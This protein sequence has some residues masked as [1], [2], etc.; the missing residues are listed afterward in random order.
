MI[1]GGLAI[2]SRKV[3]VSNRAVAK[4]FPPT[5]RNSTGTFVAVPAEASV[6][7][8]RKEGVDNTRRILDIEVSFYAR[9]A[10]ALRVRPTICGHQSECGS[11]RYIGPQQFKISL[12]QG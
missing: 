9:F 1:D 7:E 8:P 6:P 12:R 2:P 3:V 10:W 11:R 4:L 5:D